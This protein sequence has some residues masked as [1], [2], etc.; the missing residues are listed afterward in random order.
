[1]IKTNYFQSKLMLLFKGILLCF[2]LYFLLS[3]SQKL[4]ISK[5]DI[6]NYWALLACFSLTPLNW[7]FEWIKWQMILKQ[8]DEQDNKFNF[9]AFASGI[10]SSF[11]T[12]SLSGNFLGRMLFYDKSKRWRI[13]VFSSI[14]N[15]SQFLV[16]IFFGLFAFA[17]LK[18]SVSFKFNFYVF[19]SSSIV[20]M[21]LYFFGERIA[22]KIPINRIQLWCNIIQKS[23]SRLT[24]LVLSF[25]RFLIF[26]LQYILALKAFGL[27]IE[28]EIIH[29]IL[30]VFL[31]ITLSPSL[32]FGKI[33]VRESIAVFIFSMFGYET[34]PV[35]F[36]SFTTWF[37][38]LFLTAVVA[39]FIVKKTSR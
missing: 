18:E 2:F 34:T 7:F 16:S 14:A 5:I 8:L 35:I 38:N 12:P 6:E 37:F 32:F 31:L 29:L 17:F 9:K 27:A 13:T 11:L 24:L 23:P 4:D 30:I 21:F 28:F 25:M 20:L 10:I 26:V 22:V 3:R 33:M 19:I 36:A 1:L 39:L 15:F